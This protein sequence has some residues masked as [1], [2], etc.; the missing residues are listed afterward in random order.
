[1]DSGTIFS[2]RRNTEEYDAGENKPVYHPF[3]K[4]LRQYTLLS[5]VKSNSTIRMI[6]RAT[7]LY[8]SNYIRSKFTIEKRRKITR[9]NPPK[10]Q[11]C[12]CWEICKEEECIICE[13]L[14]MNSTWKGLHVAKL[15]LQHRWACLLTSMWSMVCA[16]RRG[17]ELGDLQSPFQHK[18]FYSSVIF[19][20]IHIY[21]FANHANGFPEGLQENT[22]ASRDFS[23]FPKKLA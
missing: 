5:E 23:R 9:S 20:C 16:S 10:Q 19:I 17:L 2:V 14:R 4:S 15:C 13:Q 8:H 18:P 7:E 12:H 3:P 6:H 11:Q 1:M 22:K 21:T